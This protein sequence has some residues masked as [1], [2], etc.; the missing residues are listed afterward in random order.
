[1]SWEGD[2]P[3]AAVAEGGAAPPTEEPAPAPQ[4]EPEVPAAESTL[5]EASVIEGEYSVEVEVPSTVVVVIC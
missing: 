1:M 5:L 3:A 4:A 2:E